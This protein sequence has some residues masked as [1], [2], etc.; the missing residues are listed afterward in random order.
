MI[1]P[2]LGENVYLYGAYYD[3][4]K[5]KFPK[6]EENWTSIIIYVHPTEEENL[7]IGSLEGFFVS[8]ALEGFPN[9]LC[10]REQMKEFENKYSGRFVPF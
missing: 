6:K 5:V 7:I 10:K 2:I 9:F 3:S 4:S 8:N 1:N